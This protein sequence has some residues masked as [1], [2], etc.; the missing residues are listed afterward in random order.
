MQVFHSE[1]PAG[2]KDDDMETHVILPSAWLG[3]SA[4]Q[5]GIAGHSASQ[6]G[7]AG[8]SVLQPGIAGNSQ[9]NP[10][11][12]G[13]SVLYPGIGAQG[14]LQPPIGSTP[15]TRLAAA[16]A[17]LT[18]AAP[19]HGF[20]AEWVY[21]PS[22]PALLAEAINRSRAC[23]AR[24]TD[25][26]REPI[27]GAFVAARGDS[28]D[29]GEPLW[30][31]GDEPRALAVLAD[32]NW[33]FAVSDSCLWYLE[34]SDNSGRTVNFEE[35]ISFA[36]IP[37]DSTEDRRWYDE[38]IDKVLRAAVEREDRLPEILSQADG[39]MAFFCI[40][41]GIRPARAPIT[42]ALL[43]IAQRWATPL[44]MALKNQVAAR[45]PDAAST[46]VVPVIETPAHGS[47]PSG[48]ATIATLMARLL[49][50]LMYAKFGVAHPK[51]LQLDRL[52]RR[53]AFNRVVAGV[54]FP[55]D[56]RAGY[57]LGLQLAGHFVGLAD[58]R[59]QPARY[60]LEL[61]LPA[62]QE[63]RTEGI[64]KPV[65]LRR[66]NNSGVAESPVLGL[67]WRAARRELAQLG[68]PG[69]QP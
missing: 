54:H 6:P 22:G 4:L 66:S 26:R 15:G 62:K 65:P 33:R 56:S 30:R 2:Q 31:W 3:G 18:A 17:R 38:Q 21:D 58:G 55:I 9:L 53:I 35:S 14:E 45:R 34:K 52:A 64:L 46:R 11:I 25:P 59:A 48:H 28:T 7:I 39:F 41:V 8:N 44:V 29:E 10:G 16:A 13:H 63:L 32:L 42:F 61:E 19:W 20:A 50:E 5:P 24:D 37:G 47:L 23:I 57:A 51:V 43:D 68:V 69:V 27:E 60:D 40:H 67:V 12:A 49:T 1:R 36:A